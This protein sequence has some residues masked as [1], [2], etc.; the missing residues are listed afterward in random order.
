MPCEPC[1]AAVPGSVLPERE[2]PHERSSSVTRVGSKRVQT[3]DRAIF[4]NLGFP[5]L[6]GNIL[7]CFGL[8]CT[9]TSWPLPTLCQVPAQISVQGPAQAPAPAPASLPFP[10]S[11][12]CWGFPSILQPA[13]LQDSFPSPQAAPPVPPKPLP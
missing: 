6:K 8:S 11:N 4:Q 10:I 13:F 2:T 9:K 5:A 7:L 3:T 12:P 1:R